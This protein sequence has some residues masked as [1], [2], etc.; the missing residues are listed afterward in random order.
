MVTELAVE[1]RALNCPTVV[2]APAKQSYEEEE[3]DNS[4]QARAEHSLGVDTE[5]AVECRALNCPTIVLAP[6]TQSYAE[7]KRQSFTFLW[8]RTPS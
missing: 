7:E 8:R 5:L 1:C 6:A 2:L 3:R 4:I